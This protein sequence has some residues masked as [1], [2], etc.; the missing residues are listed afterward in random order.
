M[1]GRCLKLLL[2]DE[3][4]AFGRGIL[5]RLGIAEVEHVGADKRA[6]EDA[7]GVKDHDDSRIRG[8]AA[9][10]VFGLIGAGSSVGT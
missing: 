6:G 5:A 7:L 4:A 10:D 9:V 1:A 8:H 3:T 2:P